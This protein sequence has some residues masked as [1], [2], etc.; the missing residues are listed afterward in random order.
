MTTG[1]AH[2]LAVDD[3]VSLTNMS[4]A[5]YDGVYIVK[6]IISTT[7]FE[8]AAVFSAT[9]TGTVDQAATLE[10]DTGSAGTYLLTWGASATSA[11]SNEV[12]DWEIYNDVTVV[13]GSKSRRKFGIGSDYGE[14]GKSCLLTVAD[15]DKIWF[16]FTNNDSAGNVTIRNFTLTLTEI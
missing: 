4:V 8:V 10:A 12:F 16:G 2:G 9:A 3:I 13:A 6:A 15:G 11:T 5:A 14:F 7:Q 1:T